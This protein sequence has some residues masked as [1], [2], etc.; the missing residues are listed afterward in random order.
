MHEVWV[1][2]VKGEPLLAAVV[3]TGDS[4][5]LS[6]LDALKLELLLRLR[7]VRVVIKVLAVPP[8]VGHFLSLC[9]SGTFLPKDGTSTH[10]A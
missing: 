8:L 10:V 2:G 7:T 6:L 9:G 1:I 5:P 4:E 3:S